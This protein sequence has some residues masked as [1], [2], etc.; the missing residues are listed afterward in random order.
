MPELRPFGI[1]PGGGRTLAQAQAGDLV[2]A[3]EAPEFEIVV[4]RQPT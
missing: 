4:A 2:G 1:D 3:E